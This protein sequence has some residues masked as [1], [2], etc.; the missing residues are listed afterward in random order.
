MFDPYAYV[1]KKT[2]KNTANRFDSFKVDENQ[3]ISIE[4]ANFNPEIN[5]KSDDKENL[6]DKH[7]KILILQFYIKRYLG[8]RKIYKENISLLQKKLNDLSILKN[9]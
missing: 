9:I 5:K 3:K 4:K 1:K 7:K 6:M 2:V 8:K